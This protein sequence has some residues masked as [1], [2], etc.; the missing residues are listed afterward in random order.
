MPLKSVRMKEIKPKQFIVSEH[1]I[2]KRSVDQSSIK[3]FCF[4]LG[5]H[6]NLSSL[7]VLL[8]AMHPNVQALNHGHEV[9]FPQRS[10][11]DF[12]DKE[13]PENLKWMKT[14]SDKGFSKFIQQIIEFSCVTDNDG[15][16]SPFTTLNAKRIFGHNRITPKSRRLSFPCIVDVHYLARIYRQHPLYPLPNLC[17]F[18]IFFQ[19]LRSREHRRTGRKLLRN[20]FPHLLE[21]AELLD[22]A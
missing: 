7:S 11:G 10:Q 15:Y 6:R 9:L 8:L 18:E 16:G 14:Y 3:S 1:E 4:F 20:S 2:T 22:F 17:R 13:L 19:T 21:T 12:R 5:P